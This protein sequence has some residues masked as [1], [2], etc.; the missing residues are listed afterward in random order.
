MEKTREE[1]D[2]KPEY[3]MAKIHAVLLRIL[4]AFD[5]VC[6]QKGLSYQLTGGTLL[7]CIR[8]KGFIPWD[9]DV[10]IMMTREDYDRLLSLS[11]SELGKRIFVQTWKTD[12]W[13]P[14]LFTKIYETEGG[15]RDHSELSRYICIDVFPLDNVRP[16][17]L[18]GRWQ[19]F[20]AY[21]L[22]RMNICRFLP[23]SSLTENKT[24]RFFIRFWAFISRL[25]TKNAL[26]RLSHAVLTRYRSVDC[27]YGL[28]LSAIKSWQQFFNT[29]REKKAFL[30]TIPGEFEGYYFPIPSN[31]HEILTKSYGEY[32]SLP[33]Q[34]E[35]RPSHIFR[36]Y[37]G[38]RDTTK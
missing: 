4:I 26:R 27:Q 34:S 37:F 15:S 7:G 19:L 12:E 22:V 38:R 3:D 16:E 1:R 29:M 25:I 23:A 21:V 33:P 13:T 18:G 10:D 30:R 32:M 8:H 31:Y 6:K 2:K 35:R 9:D 36:G 28:N 20:L 24:K 11:L 14:Y 17:T 5:G